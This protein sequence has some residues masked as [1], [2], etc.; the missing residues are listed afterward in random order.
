MA[1]RSNSPQQSP[2]WPPI[3]TKCHKSL[4]AS[5]APSA[6]RAIVVP[7]TPVSTSAGNGNEESGPSVRRPRQ[8][9]KIS[10]HLRPSTAEHRTGRSDLPLSRE[11]RLDRFYLP[12]RRLGQGDPKAL[13]NRTSLL[14]RRVR[15]APARTLTTT[16][17]TQRRPVDSLRAEHGASRPPPKKNWAVPYGAAQKRKSP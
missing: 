8:G 17:T 14:G 3:A 10:C 2:Q 12:R 16:K 15:A 11:A 1:L 5:Q 9:F 7:P 13:R 6:T 4:R